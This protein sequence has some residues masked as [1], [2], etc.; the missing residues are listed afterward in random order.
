MTFAIIVQQRGEPRLFALL[1]DPLLSGHGAAV[2]LLDRRC[3]FV[4]C[5]HFPFFFFLFLFLRSMTIAESLLLTLYV[6]KSQVTH[7]QFRLI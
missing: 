3:D 6:G 4:L 1:V 5:R 7:P 2:R